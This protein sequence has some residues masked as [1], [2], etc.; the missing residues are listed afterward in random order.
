MLCLSLWK[1]LNRLLEKMC[2]WLSHKLWM[3]RSCALSIPRLLTCLHLLLRLVHSTR[4][5][6]SLQIGLMVILILCQWKSMWYNSSRRK[7]MHHILVS[8]VFVITVAKKDTWEPHV[9]NLSMT[10]SS[11]L[12]LLSRQLPLS[13]HY[14]FHLHLGEKTDLCR[15]WQLLCS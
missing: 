2:C 15:T 10:S 5:T 3:K 14:L 11:K 9:S 8:N 7:Q 1:D 12:W 6:L 4:R 13:S